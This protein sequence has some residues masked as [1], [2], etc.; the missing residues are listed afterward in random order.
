MERRTFAATGS[1]R[2]FFLRADAAA[3]QDELRIED[4][5]HAR[6]PLCDLVRPVVDEI[7]HQRVSCLGRR[8]DGPAIFQ[9]GVN[10]GAP[11]TRAV[12]EAY[13]SQQPTA[14]QVQSR[15]CWAWVR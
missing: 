7:E 10:G 9:V 15:P 2:N 11:R 13:C 8:K 6:Q 12:V 4:V 5:H 14:P 3:D 1:M